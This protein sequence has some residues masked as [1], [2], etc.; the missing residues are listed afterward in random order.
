MYGVYKKVIK[1][2]NVFQ[3][4]EEVPSHILHTI[5]SEALQQFL[6]SFD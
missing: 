2:V 1:K 5:S 4:F 3:S 6:P